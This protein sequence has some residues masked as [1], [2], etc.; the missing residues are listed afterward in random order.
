MVLR[1]SST[2][3]FTASPNTGAEMGVFR[4]YGD[5]A[6]QEGIDAGWIVNSSGEERGSFKLN[7]VFQST[8]KKPK[9]GGTNDGTSNTLLFN[10]KS[11]SFG[12]FF[13]QRSSTG[14]F[15]IVAPKN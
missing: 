3:S 7:S 1:N 14:T 13:L 9:I 12:R 11:F 6:A 8:P 15:S 10:G 4:V 5:E 2:H